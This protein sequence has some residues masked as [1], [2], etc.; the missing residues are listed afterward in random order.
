VGVSKKDMRRSLIVSVLLLF[1]GSF[2][3]GTASAG[4]KRGGTGKRG[5]DAAIARTR[6]SGKSKGSDGDRARHSKLGKLGKVGQGR[7]YGAARKRDRRARRRPPAP[8]PMPTR[9]D[10]LAADQESGIVQV[11]LTGPARPPHARLFVLTDSRGRRF[12]PAVA[13]CYALDGNAEGS[14]EADAPLPRWRCAMSIPAAYRRADLTGVSMEWG[15]RVIQALPGQVKARW[16]AAGGTPLPVP[17]Q[18]PVTE[19]GDEGPQAAAPTESGAPSADPQAP[20]EKSGG[21]APQAGRGPGEG[22]PE[23]PERAEPEDIGPE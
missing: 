11:H 3:D 23:E 15:D 8:P 17:T 19:P 14:G 1:C 18:P 20:S 12:L 2:L 22:Q 4:G 21:H 13:E 9:I 7:S 6:S 16:A 5:H 10:V